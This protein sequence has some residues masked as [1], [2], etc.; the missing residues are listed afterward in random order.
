MSSAFLVFDLEGRN[1]GPKRECNARGF[2]HPAFDDGEAIGLLAG[3]KAWASSGRQ[4]FAKGDRSH[5]S[6]FVTERQLLSIRSTRID[7]FGCRSGQNA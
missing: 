6:D 3:E 5:Q 7:F 4:S 1:A 2:I